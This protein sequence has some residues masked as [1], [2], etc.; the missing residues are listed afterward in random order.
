[1]KPA[2]SQ[3]GRAPHM[4]RSLTVPH[5]ASR[6]MSPPGKKSGLT[7]WESV[8]NA[9]RAPAGAGQ[10]R[11]IV[12]RGERRVRKG[13]LENPLDQLLGQPAAATVGQ[14]DFRVTRHRGRTAEV[15]GV[16]GGGGHNPSLASAEALTSRQPTFAV[17]GD[18]RISR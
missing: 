17:F 13:R 11:A 2:L 7:T 5:T 9:S 3:R 14:L 18:C 15:R 10:Q 4:A 16:G 8:V 6:P 1:M 12:A